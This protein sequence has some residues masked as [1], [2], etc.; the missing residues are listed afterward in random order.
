MTPGLYILV[1]LLAGAASPGTGVLRVLLL[2]PKGSGDLTAQTEI[3]AGGGEAS[4]GTAFGSGTP[5][6]LTAKQIYRKSPSA[7]VDFGA[8]TAGAGAATKNITFSG[9]PTANTSVEFDIHGR[10][11]EV[12]WN[13]AESADTFKTRAIT[14]ITERSAD[15]AVTASSGGV[16]VV[17]LTGKVTGRI[18]ND[19]KVRARIVT[20]SGTAASDTAAYANLAGGTTDPDFTTILAAAAGKEYAF[21]VAC[22]SNTDAHDATASSNCERILTHIDTY[23]SGLNAKLQT[24]IFASTGS[25]ASAK[26]AAIARNDGRAEHVL[27]ENG[28]S[29]PCE[30][31]GRECGGWLARLAT[32]SNPNRIGEVLDGIYGSGDVLADTPTAAEAEDMLGNGVAVVSYT[33]SGDPIIVRPIST[34]SQDAGGGADRRLLDWNIVQAIYIVS[35]DLRS[36]LP[37]AFPQAKV[38]RDAEASEDPPPKGVLEERDIKAF[39]IS[40]LR[41]WVREGVLLGSALDEVIAS[42]DLI[43]E[44]NDSDETQVDIV[45][46]AKVV[47]VLAKMGVVVQRRAS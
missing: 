13:A 8:P 18:S 1:D 24:A 10:V 37:Q 42:G 31:A 43:V 22:L 38:M 20:A 11:F 47:P 16:G 15:L 17:T 33:M 2:S 4:A 26:T 29:L 34:Y 27:V 45:I 23:D 41:F 6:H 36:A 35:R 39:V 46:P 40:R 7:Q 32:E 3:R 5:G 9:S 44:V 28:R 30:V 19:V 14:R 12:E 21:I 25:Q